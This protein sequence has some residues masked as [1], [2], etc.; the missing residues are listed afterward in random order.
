MPLFQKGDVKVR[1]KL[2]AHKR[3]IA[4]IVAGLLALIMAISVAAP[5]VTTW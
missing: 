2:I 4:G 1:K 3:L 5:F